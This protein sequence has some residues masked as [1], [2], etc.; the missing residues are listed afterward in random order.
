MG[1]CRPL[2]L[3]VG[4]CVSR[5]HCVLHVARFRPTQRTLS[6]LAMQERVLIGEVDF[7]C[8]Q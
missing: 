3:C 6:H 2:A 8:A 5:Q 4:G 1:E 7:D